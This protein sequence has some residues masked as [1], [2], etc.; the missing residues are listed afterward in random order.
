MT[1]LSSEELRQLIERP[2]ETSVS[3][4][5]PTERAGDTQ[6]N[7]IRLKNLLREAEGKLADVGIEKDEAGA[8]LRP[9]RDL[10]SDDLFWQHQADGFVAFSSRSLFRGYR[11]PLKLPQLVMVSG[12]FHIKPLIS[13]FSHDALF[14]VL[15]LSQNDVRLLQCTRDSVR[16]IT[17]EAVPRSLSEAL[18]YDDP[19][20][21]V[22]FHTGTGTGTGKGRRSAMFHGHAVGTDDKKDN[23]LRFLHQVDRGIRET[24]RQEQAPLVVAAVDY[25]H[26]LYRQANTYANIM[27]ARLE[28]NFDDVNAQGLQQEAWSRIVAPYLEEQLTQSIG[29]YHEL[30]AKGLG[31]QDIKEIVLAV[32]DG[33]VAELFVATGLQQWGSFDHARRLVRLHE[34]AKPGDDDL[35]DL[36]AAQTLLGRGTVYAMEPE[37]VPNGG[38]A[39]AIL[40]Y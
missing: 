23:I 38:T 24:L 33:R 31:T 7:P 19:E 32:H 2:S 12:R 37:N 28:G 4:Y 11:L 35:L 8:L 5:M 20:R 18:K 21:Q 3:L 22:Q 27:E 10:L 34:E 40:R 39:A 25:L 14:Y 16:E 6:Q 29:R 1:V 30:S 13:F 9:L 26:P 17:P 36:A 15:A